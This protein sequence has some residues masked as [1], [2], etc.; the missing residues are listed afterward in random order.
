MRKVY[1]DSNATTVTHPDVVNE[2][3]PF[4]S[5]R[6]GNASSVHSFGREAKKHLEK[7]RQR[8]AAS[9][10]AG[11]ADEIIFTSGGTEA[12]NYA[13]IG[14]AEALKEKGRHI[15][16]S[17]VEHNAVLNACCRL[18]KTGYSV[19]YLG[20]DEYGI[21]DPSEVKANIK[22]DTILISVMTANNE[23]GTIMPVDEIGGIAAEKGIVFH[24]DA[25]QAV[26][27]VPVDARRTGAHLVSLSAHKIHGPKG[28]GALYI[29]KGT[30]I[31]PVTYGG[32]QEKGRRPGTENVPG[33]VGFGKACA[34]ALDGMSRHAERTKSLRDKLHGR[35]KRGIKGIKLN[36]HPEKR[37]PNTLNL[38]FENLE[39]ESII[40]G[41]DLEGVAVSTGSACT[42][43]SLEPSHVLK[44]MK[45]EPSFLQGSVRFSFS[46]FNT[47]DEVIYVAE[48]LTPIIDRLRK[49]S[50]VRKMG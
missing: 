22:E 29:K 43:G 2:M 50:P 37:L 8:V 27:K 1:L 38:S 30:K 19:T 45:V 13:I 44:S 48:K 47:E 49:I 4:F 36:G 32:H 11:S 6:Y 17:S 12:D 33:I 23:T 14:A 26:G 7:S 25:V 18:E 41:L 16:T 21:V 35:I 46:T 20:V 15:I 39:G 9:I 10:N 3:L 34:I 40:L 28:V 42:S 31:E 24:T 5:E